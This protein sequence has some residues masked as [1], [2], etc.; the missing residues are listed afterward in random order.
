M[1][2]PAVT[3]KMSPE[4]FGDR[5]KAKYPQ[6]KDVP[7][8]TL[9]SKIALKYPQYAKQIDWSAAPPKQN[10]QYTPPNPHPTFNKIAQGT[11]NSA[12]AIGGAAGG[13]LGMISPVPGG[14]VMGA[15]AGGMYGRDIQQR[16]SGGPVSEKK[17][18]ESGA[19]QG[20]L[21]Y[22][23]GTLTPKILEKAG[24]AAG[25]R[26]LK[27]MNNYIGMSRSV[28]PKFGRTVENAENIARTVLNE[29]GVAK[30]LPAQ[31]EAIEAARQKVDSNMVSMLQNVAKQKVVSAKSIIRQIGQQEADR[32]TREA[33]TGGQAAVNA[34]VAALEKSLPRDF[35][36]ASE[37]LTWRREFQKNITDWSTESQNVEQ[38]FLQNVYHE[39]NDAIVR[40]LPKAEAAA[41]KNANRIQNRLIY[42]R[43]AADSTMLKEGLKKTQGIA[44]RLANTVVKT[45]AGAGIGGLIGAEYGHG[46]ESAKAGALVGGLA[47]LGL[48]RG[49]EVSFPAADIKASQALAKVLPSLAKAA[50]I[51]PEAAR[52]A[53]I[54]LKARFSP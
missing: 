46:A 20:G 39:V 22:V 36:N 52:T 31:R 8:A 35:L 54:A 37:L 29:A 32:L 44:S 51:S 25:P 2:T 6:Y 41:F 9:A 49:T 3:P 10:V 12:P 23:G 34:N 42:A 15:A 7:N 16:A 14:S 19:I 48:D 38:R 53:Y 27:A 47:G 13:I 17:N 45:A 18:I 30:N 33:V 26:A 11:V 1:S 4:D 5:I 21:E 24:A 40:A 50:K 28:L 43:T